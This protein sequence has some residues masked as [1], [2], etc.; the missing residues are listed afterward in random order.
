MMGTSYR[1]HC[2]PVAPG[3]EVKDEDMCIIETMPV[4]SLITNSKESG[5]I[6]SK[7]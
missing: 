2:H 4:K 1:V 6:I 3:E 7:G 5:A